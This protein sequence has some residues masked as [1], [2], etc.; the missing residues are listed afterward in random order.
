MGAN[1]QQRKNSNEMF[2]QQM[3]SA[4]LS[5]HTQHGRPQLLLLLMLHIRTH[6]DIRLRML[7]PPHSQCDLNA[8]A[9]SLTYLPRMCFLLLQ[10]KRK[11]IPAHSFP[12]LLMHFPYP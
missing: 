7:N 12:P 5:A 4:R 1:A 3:H 9:R 11:R 10:I 2:N 6:L 8:S